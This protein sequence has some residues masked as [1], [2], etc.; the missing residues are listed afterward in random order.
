MNKIRTND[1][2]KI[3]F[4]NLNFI[5]ETSLSH[6]YLPLIGTK[7][8]EL[9]LWF[10]TEQVLGITS[11]DNFDQTH[12]RILNYLKLDLNQFNNLRQ[13]LEEYGLLKTYY[14][15]VN[16]HYLYFLYKPLDVN[17]FTKNLHFIK[18][19]INTIGKE[20]YEKTLMF[21]KPV[22]LNG[23]Y[24]NISSSLIQF[25][26]NKNINELSSSGFYYFDFNKLF[27]DLIKDNVI[28]DLTNDEHNLI[29]TYF[30]S[31]QF[32]YLDIFNATKNSLKPLQK[33][34]LYGLNISIFQNFMKNLSLNYN[35]KKQ[36]EVIKVT[37]DSNNNMQNLRNIELFSDFNFDENLKNEIFNWYENY[38]FNQFYKIVIKDEPSSYTIKNLNEIIKKY[39]FNNL[40][41]NLIADFVIFETSKFNLNY[42]KKVC[43]T[44]NNLNLKNENDILNHLRNFKSHNKFHTNTF[45]KNSF[46]KQTVKET[47]YVETND[48]NNEEFNMNLFLE[49]LND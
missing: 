35:T 3:I 17:E 23:I 38:S 24:E 2:Y 41:V 5:D 12:A 7:A 40:I 20:E 6:L 39:D 46:K 49:H 28:L 10:R 22:E 18:A 29:E 4:N 37:N 13:I 48:A 16:N 14:D 26:E 42:F 11:S 1:I 9:Y 47:N 30:K 36:L 19:L 34:G 31:N 33:N 25:N 32:S 15:D 44:I 27:S 21:L 45:N 43:Q 8:Y